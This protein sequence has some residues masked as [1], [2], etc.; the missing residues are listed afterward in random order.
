MKRL[1]LILASALFVAG[2]SAQVVETPVMVKTGILL[3]KKAV[4]STEI[5][6]PEIKG[7]YA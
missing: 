3:Y 4:D 6:L 1:F 2:A 5:F 7:Y